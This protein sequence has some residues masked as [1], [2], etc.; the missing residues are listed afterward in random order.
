[1]AKPS[2]G[3]PKPREFRHR[4]DDNEMLAQLC[5]S[6]DRHVKSMAMACLVTFPP[7]RTERRLQ[8]QESSQLCVFG[9]GFGEYKGTILRIFTCGGHM[10]RIPRADVS[11]KKTLRLTACGNTLI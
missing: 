6:F 11:A 3:M 10:L 9:H 5:S 7:Y 1:M 2:Y 4:K 8:Q